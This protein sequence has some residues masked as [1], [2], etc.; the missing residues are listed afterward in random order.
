[1]KT[2]WLSLVVSLHVLATPTLA[3]ASPGGDVPLVHFGQDVLA[4]LTGTIGPVIFGIGLAIAAIS[5]VMGSREGIQKAIW[6]VI[7]G[8]LLF[9]VHSVVAFVASHT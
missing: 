6:A 2:S 5:M 1:M 8:A 9:G 7:G 3:Q 4:F